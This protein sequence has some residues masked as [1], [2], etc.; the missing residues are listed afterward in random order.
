MKKGID[1]ISLDLLQKEG[2]IGIRRAKKRN[3]ERIPLACGGYSVNSE[4]DL[5]PECLGWAGSVYEHV[6]EEDKFTFIED[7]KNPMSCTILLRGPSRHTIEQ[8]KDAIHDGLRAVKNVFI[9]GCV[10]AGAGCFEVQTYQHLMKYKSNV[11]GRKKIGVQIFADALLSIPRILVSN[12]G[13]DPQDAIL[14]LLAATENGKMVGVDVF[15]GGVLSPKDYG[16]YDNYCVKKQFLHLGSII[17]EKLLLVD[18]I[19][20]AGRTKSED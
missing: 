10:I 18:E 2:I 19:I 9:D 12:A 11:V 17:A 7:V 8:V 16:I 13:H 4:K 6:L 15:T 3:M 1:P 5:V 14:A 20:R